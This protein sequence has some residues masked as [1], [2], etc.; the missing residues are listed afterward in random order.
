MDLVYL[1]TSSKRICI[2]QGLKEKR[3]ITSFHFIF[4]SFALFQKFLKLFWGHSAQTVLGLVTTIETQEDCRNG[5]IWV[6]WNCTEDAFPHLSAHTDSSCAVPCA[7]A[8]LSTK[9]YFSGKSFS[10]SPFSEKLKTSTTK[11]TEQDF[12]TNSLASEK[13]KKKKTLTGPVKIV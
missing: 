2:Y 11:G 4:P 1:N 13:K 10:Y 12:R 9:Q 8:G 6:T 7:D 3:K 5:R